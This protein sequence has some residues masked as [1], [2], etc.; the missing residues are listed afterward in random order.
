[1][2]DPATPI[3]GRVQVPDLGIRPRG[4][5]PT[6]HV[7]YQDL[8]ARGKL[9]PLGL[10]D[11]RHFGAVGDGSHDD[12]PAIQRAITAAGRGGRSY[13]VFVPPG[14]YRLNSGLTISDRGVALIGVGEQ[15]SFLAGS[16]TGNM[17]TITNLDVLLDGLY[18]TV[19]PGVTRTAGAAVE[20]QNTGRPHLRD[21]W[22]NAQF[23]A[24]YLNSTNDVHARS[25][26]FINTVA[27]GN[28][29]RINGGNEITLT[30]LEMTSMA[31]GKI[32]I[33]IL[34][35]PASNGGEGI[36]I[37]NFAVISGGLRGIHLDPAPGNIQYVH[38][39]NGEIADQAEGGIYIGP[40]GGYTCRFITIN[41]VNVMNCGGSASVPA[42]IFASLGVEDVHLSDVVAFA[43]GREGIRI[44][45]GNSSVVSC[46]A[47]SN[48]TETTNTYDGILV[49]G[50]GASTTDGTR[51]SACSSR[52]ASQRYGINLRPGAFGCIAVG[53]DTRG[54][55]T[56]GVNDASVAPKDVNHNLG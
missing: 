51:I 35:D 36:R 45:S 52:G 27:N 6:D 28:D 25:M 42:A 20:V 3:D 22:F 14:N 18:F 53:N 44:S 8:I 55:G 11:I 26:Q 54:N 32:G 9:H 49:G 29:I 1:M 31:A 7:G 46:R 40:P 16:A 15:S 21:V 2:V 37:D 17:L 47:L 19:A 13:G 38:I 10:L 5:P 34:G 48:S 24:L 4:I 33:Y 23:W 12:A 56:G 30:D 50:G 43:N 41:S 39:S